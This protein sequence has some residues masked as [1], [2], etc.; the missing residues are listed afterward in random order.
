M[1]NGEHVDEEAL[2]PEQK[3]LVFPKMPMLH[4]NFLLFS[5]CLISIYFYVS[6]F[7]PSLHALADNYKECIHTKEPPGQPP[8]PVS[9]IC[10]G[11]V[12]G[13]R[14]E[15]ITDTELKHPS[16]ITYVKLFEVY[17]DIHGALP[18]LLFVLSPQLL[19][20]SALLFLFKQSKICDK[21]EIKVT[22]D[23][24]LEYVRIGKRKW[25][26]FRIF[27]FPFDPLNFF[28]YLEIRQIDQ[29]HYVANFYSSEGISRSMERIILSKTDVERIYDFFEKHVKHRKIHKGKKRSLIWI[30]L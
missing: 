22:D 15:G 5:M 18:T 30:L 11:I 9:E 19:F 13:V 7:G 14:K 8:D 20:V 1:L 12:Q 26:T 2:D 3:D 16:L 29:N 4:I 25:P 24:K 21:L 17:C 28:N 27:G 23:G 10:T 6:Y